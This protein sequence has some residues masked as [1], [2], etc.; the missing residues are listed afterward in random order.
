MA[1]IVANLFKFI[2]L[3]VIVII[4]FN[5]VVP[6]MFKDD[7]DKDSYSVGKA[8]NSIERRTYGD[9]E[10]AS[11]LV[12]DSV[13]GFSLAAEDY[14]EEDHPEYMDQYSIRPFGVNIK[15]CQNEFTQLL[16]WRLK[17]KHPD[18]EVE[19]LVVSENF[20]CEDGDLYIKDEAL[21]LSAHDFFKDAFTREGV[22]QDW[23]TKYKTQQ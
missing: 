15:Y 17:A 21:V 5:R 18:N 22:L 14:L 20:G 8:L 10:V 3:L 9:Y 1:K 4:V 16:I 2:A 13:W 11:S 6:M 7:A 12:D 23:Y 19:N